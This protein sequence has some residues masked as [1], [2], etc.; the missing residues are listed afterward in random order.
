[1]IQNQRLP[2]GNWQQKDFC[3]MNEVKKER[4]E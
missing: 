4:K 2:E 3:Q 1:M